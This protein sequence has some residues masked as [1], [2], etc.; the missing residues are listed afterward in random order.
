MNKEFDF[1]GRIN[2]IIDFK[3]FKSISDFAKNGIGYVS[4]E[5]INRLKNPKKRPSVEILLDISNKFADIDPGWLLTG[6]GSMT[7]GGQLDLGE[8]TQGYVTVAD[9]EELAVRVKNLERYVL[10]SEI[11][12]EEEKKEIG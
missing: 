9:Y 3:G 11:L 6:R 10:A 5:K 1:Y 2:Q 7:K 12:K 8:K 4:P